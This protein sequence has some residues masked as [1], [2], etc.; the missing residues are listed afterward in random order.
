MA[1]FALSN[2]DRAVYVRVL[3]NFHSKDFY[4]LT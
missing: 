1:L 4:E 3:I 2:F